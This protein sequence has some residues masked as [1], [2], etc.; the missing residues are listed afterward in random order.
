[1][2][3]EGLQLHGTVGIIPVEVERPV[4]YD[5]IPVAVIPAMNCLNPFLQIIPRRIGGSPRGNK[6]LYLRILK[7]VK[8]PQHNPYM[9]LVNQA[10]G[11]NVQ[12]LRHLILV[13]N[14]RPVLEHNPVPGG[15]N[16]PGSNP[17]EHPGEAEEVLLAEAPP[18]SVDLQFIA[19]YPQAPYWFKI[20][21]PGVA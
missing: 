21:L 13:I 5:K 11:R 12:P 7:A 19:L 9:A 6:E 15:I 16:L 17:L 18:V 20:F 3:P 8:G 4:A 14:K 1:M 2:V 10:H